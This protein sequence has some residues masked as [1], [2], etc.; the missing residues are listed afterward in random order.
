MPTVLC[1]RA[2]M[3]TLCKSFIWSLLGIF[4]LVGAIDEPLFDYAPPRGHMP[5]IILEPSLKQEVANLIESLKSRTGHE[6]IV[7]TGAPGVGK[8]T[9]AKI[10]LKEVQRPYC[11]VETALLGS[12][13]TEEACG[14]LGRL[15]ERAKV[16]HNRLHIIIFDE[17][18]CLFIREELAVSVR[19]KS[20][21]E[22][23]LKGIDDPA[24]NYSLCFLTNR[25]ERLHKSLI[26][27]CNRHLDIEIPA[28]DERRALLTL[29]IN[30][31]LLRGIPLPYKP[32]S[33]F[34]RVYRYLFGTPEVRI[35]PYSFEDGVFSDESLEALAEKID[36][37]SG[38]DI[39]R[40]IYGIQ[41]SSLA[42]EKTTI[43]AELVNTVVDEMFGEKLI[44]EDRKFYQTR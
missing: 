30:E 15:F 36:G 38:R 34:D 11:F 8:S 40:L 35:V 37:F 39:H 17:A 29:H 12:P 10:V 20:M 33:F 19:Q 26:D 42:D 7:V 5:T 28:K 31:I 6:T 1:E 27:A 13:N 16:A 18:D 22:I 44:E 24:R 21:L 32:N 25:P 14:W 2:N 3:Y 41:S 9:L 4:S 23:V 43:R